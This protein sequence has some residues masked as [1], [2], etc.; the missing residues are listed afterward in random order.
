[1]AGTA[2]PSPV[3]LAKSLVWIL[4]YH[5]AS[6]SLSS[7]SP[8]VVRVALV[9]LFEADLRQVLRRIPEAVVEFLALVPELVVARDVLVTELLAGLVLAPATATLFE[10]G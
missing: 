5:R 7:L 2:P 9:D 8:N 1:M 6:A 3:F 10:E 4:F